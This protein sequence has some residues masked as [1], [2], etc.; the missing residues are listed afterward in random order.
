MVGHGSRAY[1][2]LAAIAAMLGKGHDIE[3]HPGI[4]LF[5]GAH[6]GVVGSG[7]IGTAPLFMRRI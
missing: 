1:P 5:W 7:E 6:A 2:A 4:L 3:G